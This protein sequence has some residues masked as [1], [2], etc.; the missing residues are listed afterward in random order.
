M[1]LTR[2]VHMSAP[3]IGS[4]LCGSKEMLGRIDGFGPNSGFSPFSFYIFILL[5]CL[6]FILNPKFE[7]ETL[8]E[9]HL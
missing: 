3:R 6:L 5:L 4:G 2:L 8:Y 7:F 9:F 1:P